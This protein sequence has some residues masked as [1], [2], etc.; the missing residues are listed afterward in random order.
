MD[1]GGLGAT[2]VPS[3]LSCL[4]YSNDCYKPVKLLHVV[5]NDYLVASESSLC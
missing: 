3:A 2:E 1:G 5:I 4:Q